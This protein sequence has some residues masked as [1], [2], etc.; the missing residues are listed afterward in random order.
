MGVKGLIKHVHRDMLS[1]VI[2]LGDFVA[3]SNNEYGRAITLGKVVGTFPEKIKIQV[4]N[5]GDRITRV[6]PHNVMVITAQVM[7]NI[8]GNVG[9]PE[10]ENGTSD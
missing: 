9:T 4:I 6:Y 1:R 7:A 3:W 5:E 2:K 10:V 8:E